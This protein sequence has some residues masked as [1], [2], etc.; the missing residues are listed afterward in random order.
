MLVVTLALS[1]CV[2][3]AGQPE[4][5]SIREAALGRRQGPSSKCWRVVV[6]L[7]RSAEVL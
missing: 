2:A 6:C 1:A 3:A 5:A 4:S 7:V